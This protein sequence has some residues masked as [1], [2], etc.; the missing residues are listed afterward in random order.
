MQGAGISSKTKAVCSD[1]S[2]NDYDYDGD[3]ITRGDLDDVVNRDTFTQFESVFH[4]NYVHNVGTEGLYIGS[5]FYSVGKE[6]RCDSGAETVYDPVLEGVDIYNNRIAD[7]GWD[8]IQ[9][10]SAT[11]R[12]AIHHNRIRKDSRAEQRYQRSGVMN[13]PGSVCNIYSNFI[14]DGFG[15]GIYVQGNGG[16]ILYNNVIVNAGQNKD[17]GSTGGDGIHNRTGSN[18]GNSVYVLNNTI[19]NPRTFGVRFASKKGSDNRIQ[20]NIIVSPGNYESYGEDAYVQTEEYTNVTVSHNLSRQV[21]VDVKFKDPAMENYSI[22]RDS[23]AVDSGTD[24]YLKTVTT[25]YTGKVR[26]QGVSYDIGA[27]EYGFPPRP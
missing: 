26:P 15:P 23:P 16:N 9:V 8:G 7:T 1:G 12:C 22:R 4:D 17:V 25:D 19:V 5:S 24:P 13:N 20:N 27:Y 3:G 18:P 11:Q 10:G 2:T 21:L 6:V 14:K